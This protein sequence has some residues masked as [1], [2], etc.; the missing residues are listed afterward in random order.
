MDFYILI[1]PRD[2]QY[3]VVG[4]L[5]YIFLHLSSVLSIHCYRKKIQPALCRY[6]PVVINNRNMAGNSVEK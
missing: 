5:F 1:F 4:A 2:A 6:D 3:I